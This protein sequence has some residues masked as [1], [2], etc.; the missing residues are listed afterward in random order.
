M[1]AAAALFWTVFASP[2]APQRATFYVFGGLVSVE[3][4]GASRDAANAAFV[5]I[6]NQLHRDERAWHPWQ[7]PSAL[8]DLNA[9]IARGE[10]YR[11][12]PEL[13]GLIRAAQQGYHDSD[14]LFD[15][16]IGALVTAWGYHT[17]TFPV[18]T[19]SPSPARVAALDAKRPGMGDIRVAADGTVISDNRRIALDLD[20]LAEGYAAEQIATILRAHGIGNAI[21]NV[22]GDVLALGTADGRPWR[23]AIESPDGG[24]FASLQ[25]S[26]HEALFSS[27]NYHKYRMIAGRRRAHIID[28]RTGAPVEG[29]AA[30]SVIMSNATRA[31]VGSTA[32]MVAGPK[33]F[34]RI[35]RSLHASCTMLL[36]DDDHLYIMPEMQKRIALLRKPAAITIVQMPTAG[37]DRHQRPVRSD[38][39][40]LQP[41]FSAEPHPGGFRSHLPDMP[42]IQEIASSAAR[43]I[44][45][46]EKWS[47]RNPAIH[48][49]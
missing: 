32:L 19:P 41:A 3:V 36:T 10:P 24:V 5:E 28:P 46:Y 6:D 25:L 21:V 22:G 23:V 16:A 44:R 26:G 12:P 14:G 33:D 29:T 47:G 17:G 7:R 35:A 8:M 39:L 2:R 34:A 30:T 48:P 20:G 31:D 37:C 40:T 9:A 1:L 15:A 11:A 13:A 43:C 18:N 49:A 38:T 42:A 27:G 4:R 45:G